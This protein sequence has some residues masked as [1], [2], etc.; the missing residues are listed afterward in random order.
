[1]RKVSNM[2]ETVR[3]FREVLV[4]HEQRTKPKLICVDGQVVGSAVVVVSPRDPNWWRRTWSREFD[5][6]I[7]VS[8]LTEIVEQMLRRRV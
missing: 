8:V 4:E 1:M 3:N 2:P 6:E 7:R 5:G